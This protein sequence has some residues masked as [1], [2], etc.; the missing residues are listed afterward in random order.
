[1]EKRK[2]QNR[3]GIQIKKMAN[4]N[5][6]WLREDQRA[7][8]EKI[9]NHLQSDYKRTGKKR[10]ATYTQLAEELKM[11]RGSVSSACWFLAFR[12]PPFL[13]MWAEKTVSSR[14]HVHTRM[15]IKLC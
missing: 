9:F 8:C 12:D 6:V 3:K 11:Q 5:T 10:K 15:R 4:G 13:K 7:N 1:M 2:F 14:K